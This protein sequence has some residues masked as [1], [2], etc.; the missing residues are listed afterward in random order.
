MDNLANTLRALAKKPVDLVQVA[1]ALEKCTNQGN[2]GHSYFK[3]AKVFNWDHIG[4]L[5]VAEPIA[6]R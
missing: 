3:V 4:K 6:K 5:G 2:L 1:D